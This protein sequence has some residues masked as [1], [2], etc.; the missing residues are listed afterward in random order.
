MST[1]VSKSA[2]IR[3]QFGVS[4]QGGRGLFELD[5]PV[6]ISD[7]FVPQDNRRIMDIASHTVIGFIQMKLEPGIQQFHGFVRILGYLKKRAICFF[8]KIQLN[9]SIKKLGKAIKIT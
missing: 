3:M 6:S 9:G 1:E 5:I 4:G 8:Y 7:E 2:E